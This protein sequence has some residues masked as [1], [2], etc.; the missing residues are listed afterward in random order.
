MKKSIILA[1]LALLTLP[2]MSQAKKYNKAMRTA[3]EKMNEAGDPASELELVASFEEIALNYPDQWLPSYH[4]ARILVLSSFEESDGT[5]SDVMLDRAR[6][7]LDKAMNMVPEE[8]EVHA[9]EALYYIGMISADPEVRGQL[10]YQDVLDAIQ[11]SKQLNPENPRAYFMDGMMTANMPEFIG[12]GPEAAK[13]IFVEAAE[14][15]LSYQN[16]NPFW[17]AWGEDMNQASLDG[18][19]E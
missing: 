1:L 19:N 2:A 16:E 10:Y 3:I 12:G 6:K 4:A 17:P 7:S 18:L 15:F 11:K 9:L 8:S 5:K 14:K 13:P